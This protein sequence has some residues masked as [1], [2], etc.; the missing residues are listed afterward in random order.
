MNVIFCSQSHFQKAW[1]FVKTSTR[2]AVFLSHFTCFSNGIS[3]CSGIFTS[4]QNCLCSIPWHFRVSTIYSLFLL[5]SLS[6]QNCFWGNPLPSQ[7]PGFFLVFTLSLCPLLATVLLPS[8]C[9]QSQFCSYI[10]IVTFICSTS[11]PGCFL[12]I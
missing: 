1:E 4:S 9:V 3:E 8:L 11:L 5:Y 7:C 2:I 6:S 12:C 10:L